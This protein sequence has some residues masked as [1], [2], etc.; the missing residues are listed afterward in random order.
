MTTTDET[1]PLGLYEHLKSASL[2]SRAIP[3]G[4]QWQEEILEKDDY[5][6]PELL[7]QFFATQLAP[8]L[9][10]LKTPADQVE[11]VNRMMELL[12]QDAEEQNDS[13]L[14]DDGSNVIQMRELTLTDAKT[15]RPDI[16]LSDVALMTNTSKDL[17]LNTEIQKELESADRVDLLCSFL[18]MS[19]VN[20]LSEQ[21]KAIK[22]RGIPFRIITTTY[23]G[24]TDRKAIDRLVEEYGAEVKISYQGDSTRLHAKA[25]LFHRNTGMSTGYVGSSN[26][27][28]AALT[29]GLEW[30]V[31]ISNPITPGLIRQFEGLFES[32]WKS[33]DFTSYTA[34]DKEKQ[35]LDTALAK[36][37]ITGRKSKGLEYD[38]D[39]SLLD[40]HPFPHQ[41]RMLEEMQ[42]ARSKGRHRNLA[43]AATGTG[44][45]VF[46]ALDYRR[47][48]EQSGKK[49]KLLFIAHRKEILD[50]AR[51]TFGD[52]MLKGNFGE[53]L[54]GGKKPE[55]N[56]AVF[57]TIQT[58][59]GAA[60][61]N[62]APDYFDVI[63]MD[64][65]HHIKAASW[66]KVFNY[67]EPREF[68]GLTA[69]P[70]REDG[71]NIADK[72]FGGYVATSI[73]LWDALEDNLLVPFQYFGITDGTDLRRVNVRG[74]QYDETD[75]EKRYTDHKD[76]E[77]RLRIIVKELREKVDN[78]LRMKALGFCV[79]V[80]HAKYMAQK[81]NEIGIPADCL[82]GTDS[83]ERRAEVMKNLADEAHELTTI[84][85]VDLFN[86][87]IDIPSVD[88]LLMLRPT[89]SLTLFMQQLGRGLRRA[90]LKSVLTVLDFVGHQNKNF[91]IHSKYRAFARQGAL[92]EQDIES[93]DLPAG[94]HFHLD[95]LTQEQVIKKIRESLGMNKNALIS[96]VKGY[97]ENMRQDS[98]ELDIRPTVIDFINHY[99][100]GLPQIY[101]RSSK[102][103]LPGVTKPVATTW[104][105]LQAATGLYP[106]LVVPFQD[107][108][109]LEVNRRVK[110]LRHV[111]DSFRINAYLELLNT[112]IREQDMTD[113]QRRFAWMLLFSI[114]PN[115]KWVG[116]TERFSLN[117][118]LATLRKNRGILQELESVWNF[119]AATDTASTLPLFEGEDIPLRTH[120]YY[121]REELFAGLA[122][123]EE[124]FGVPTGFREGVKTFNS[125][126]T[127]AL[128]VNLE[129]SEKH[130]SPTTMYKDYAIST[131]EFA[132]DSQ[133]ATTPESPTGQ[134][135]QHH[136][137][138]SRRIVLFVRRNQKDAIGTRPY[139]CL[140]TVKYI[141]HEGSKPMHIRWSLDRPMPASMFQIAKIAS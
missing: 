53:L 30:N 80:K 89:Q 87:G 90:P 60:L 13:L 39:S 127:T 114:W 81:F 10:S 132:W 64:E 6:I 24:A 119:N 21:L 23:M 66:D 49:L 105:S 113:E 85:T 62:Y 108:I 76:A 118:G 40:V 70:E 17:N 86:E 106:D 91:M 98:A 93:P 3:E 71:V 50:Q 88:T 99:G 96:T 33:G 36:A 69:T 128:V 47:L 42:N 117:E 122:G 32:Y 16:P 59:S 83:A 126:N 112:D 7:T 130:F 72:Y 75:L 51:R 2:M 104:T 137:E 100:L 12:P 124:S 20:S 61:E 44:K 55:Y 56:E 57:A 73:R 15:T 82:V 102:V 136:E 34:S 74:G 115:A 58:L 5:N 138:Q 65:C 111:N 35:E 121:S 67:F 134:L 110:A 139:M 46:S 18:K 48:C 11:L 1:L 131:D 52:V 125:S 4:A 28:S 109:S 79:S 41:V 107:N 84:F 95:E 140:G 25:W 120:A 123:Q 103:T 9:E 29:D 22:N 27:S 97:L 37:D 8:A 94:C 31:R 101:G 14:T 45:T 19:G 129:K 77:R 92:T 63:I 78:P 141:S 135:F 26:L 133:N 54:T 38:I 68:I 116:S 43:V